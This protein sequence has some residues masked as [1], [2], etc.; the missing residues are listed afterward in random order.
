MTTGNTAQQIKVQE[1]QKNSIKES[2]I[3]QIMDSIT[4]DD[5]ISRITTD[6]SKVEHLLK[7]ANNHKLQLRNSLDTNENML[8]ETSN[9]VISKRGQ[10]TKPTIDEIEQ[11]AEFW[12]TIEGL[13]EAKLPILQNAQKVLVRESL[14]YK[15]NLKRSQEL[16][17][18]GE[19][20][21]ARRNLNDSLLVELASIGVSA[22]SETAWVS[23]LETISG[24]LNRKKA[25]Y[26]SEHGAEREM[27][28]EG[29][30]RG[31][32][33]VEEE[34][35]DPRVV[36]EQVHALLLAYPESTT[37]SSFMESACIHLAFLSDVS[38]FAYWP[39]QITP[40][41]I[42][43]PGID[44]C[45]VLVELEQTA[46]ISGQSANLVAHQVFIQS[47][48]PRFLEFCGQFLDPLDPTTCKQLAK[49]FRLL[50]ERVYKQNKTDENLRQVRK[51]VQSIEL[52]FQEVLLAISSL[53]APMRSHLGLQQTYAHLLLE[54]LFEFQWLL[55][56]TS[57]L[58]LLLKTVY[59]TF[60][61]RL[62]TEVKGQTPS[63]QEIM[64][65][66]TILAHLNRLVQ[67]KTHSVELMRSVRVRNEMLQNDQLRQPGAQ[68]LR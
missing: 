12:S 47:L 23:V 15:E 58:D 27:I 45:E 35:L 63:G 24:I 10:Q 56:Q 2:K 14:N 43:Y 3:L 16:L 25:K 28:M 39:F 52:A 54:S 57:F 62:D 11:M 65:Y 33:D 22:V 5:I 29:L 30:S 48:I 40:H 18:S 66:Q 38:F 44:G 61:D 21:D 55:P 41:Q 36:L 59:S 64:F 53:K 4:A 7:E 26:L 60:V 6:L 13:L 9:P 34:L 31:L 42:L 32:V 20:S 17:F 19:T 1:E 46:E 51:L 68:I 37:S 8:R 50:V 49:D 67:G